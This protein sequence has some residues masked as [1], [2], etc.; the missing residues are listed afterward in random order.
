MT[1]LLENYMDVFQIILTVMGAAAAIAAMTPTPKD[2]TIIAK[3]RS[4][5]DILGMNFGHA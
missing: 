3:I 1:W 4:V 2:D 5:L